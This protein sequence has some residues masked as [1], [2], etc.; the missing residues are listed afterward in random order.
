MRIDA[1]KEGCTYK[2]VSIA[3]TPQDPNGGCLRVDLFI[4]VAIPW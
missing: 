3:Y 4:G 2:G 1:E